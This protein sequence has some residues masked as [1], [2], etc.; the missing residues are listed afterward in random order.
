MCS[1][2]HEKNRTQCRK[3]RYKKEKETDLV[4]WSYRTLKANAKRRGKAFSL[5]LD[6]FRD[7]CY[8]TQLLT[9]RGTKSTSYTVDRKDNRYGYHV[10]NIQKLTNSENAKKKDKILT[11]DYETKTATIREKLVFTDEENPF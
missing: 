11:Y 3:C 8:E 10:G 2:K 1:H 5:T 6:E 7:F 4:A 9:N